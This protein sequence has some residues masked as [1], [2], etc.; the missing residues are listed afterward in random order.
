[1][2]NSVKYRIPSVIV[3]TA[4]EALAD[5]RKLLQDRVL[6]DSQLPDDQKVA[7]FESA[8]AKRLND[9]NK[10]NRGYTLDP[11]EEPLP[12]QVEPEVKKK[13]RVD[14]RPKLVR[15]PGK[16]VR[17]PLKAVK[18]PGRREYTRTKM[19]KKLG[20]RGDTAPHLKGSGRF[21]IV[22]W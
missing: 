13:R 6:T 12:Q 8:V 18:K 7:L 11:P 19:V 16:R 14:I 20:K 21:R 15:K 1:M 3:K 10:L 22:R 9:E 17:Q 4:E 2:I 5:K